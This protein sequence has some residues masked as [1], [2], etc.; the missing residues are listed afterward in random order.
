MAE[1]LI[2]VLSTEFNK[3]EEE[4]R[5]GIAARVEGVDAD[6]LDVNGWRTGN[7]N[8]PKWARLAAARW[9][10][11]LWLQERDACTASNL[12]KVDKRFTRL[13]SGFSMG[14]IISMRNDIERQQ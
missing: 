1:N 7:A 4:I 14:E 3:S 8:V 13:L 9:I 6:L 10:I 12:L 2:H 11:E 5:N